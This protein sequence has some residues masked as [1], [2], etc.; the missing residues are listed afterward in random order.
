[1]LSTACFHCAVD[2]AGMPGKYTLE[3]HKALK[4]YNKTYIEAKQNMGL[5][6]SL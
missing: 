4:S 3:C 6:F 5:Y 2:H 1:M